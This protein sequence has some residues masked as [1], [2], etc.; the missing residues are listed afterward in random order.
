MI[1]HSMFASRNVISG[2]NPASFARFFI[3]IKYLKHYRSDFCGA[4]MFFI[5]V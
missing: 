5:S 4:L 1:E 2:S 3:L